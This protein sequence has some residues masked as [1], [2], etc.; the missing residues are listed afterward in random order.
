MSS[1]F[2]IILFELS[3]YIT[4]RGLEDMRNVLAPPGIIINHAIGG[5][6]L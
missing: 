3:V 1:T 2:T 4:D 5:V 6:F